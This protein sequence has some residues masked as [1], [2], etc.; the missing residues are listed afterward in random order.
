M[1]F[2]FK[3][4]I[5]GPKNYLV[6]LESKK[7]SKSTSKAKVSKMNQNNRYIFIKDYF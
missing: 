7:K 2:G 4:I 3:N 5:Y 1:L 6:N